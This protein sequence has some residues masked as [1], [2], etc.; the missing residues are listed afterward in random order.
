MKTP[1]TIR[2]LID[3]RAR[4]FPDKPFLLAPVE[5]DADSDKR[6]RALTFG[7]LRDE[8]VALAAGFSD[9]G[10]RPGDVISVYM[11]NGHPDR[12]PAARGDVRRLVANPLN[13]LCQPSQ[14]RYIVEHSD[15]RAIF[16]VARYHAMRSRR[17][18]RSFARRGSSARSCWSRR[19]PMRSRCRSS[20]KPNSRSP[21]RRVWRISHRRRRKTWRARITRPPMSRC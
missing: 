20:R 14:V 19:S 18:S 16:V 5:D 15:T 7:E 1:V 17:P 4:Q 10:L 21:K 2:A 8:C 13:L 9:A 11:G 12:D 6:P 3:E